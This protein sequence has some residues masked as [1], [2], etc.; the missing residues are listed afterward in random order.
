MKRFFIMIFCCAGLLNL[1]G[2]RVPYQTFELNAGKDGKPQIWGRGNTACHVSGNV[3]IVREKDGTPY[4]QFSK[5]GDFFRFPAKENIR[6][7]QGTVAFFVKECDTGREQRVWNPYFQWT[8]K[9]EVF[10]VLRLWQ[11]FEVGGGL[12][13]K[14]SRLVWCSAGTPEKGIWRHIAFSWQKQ[15][16]RLYVDGR[17]Q[18]TLLP[19]NFIFRNPGEFFTVGRPSEA[20]SAEDDFHTGRHIIYD[21]PQQAEKMKIGKEPYGAFGIRDFRIF[22]RALTPSEAAALAQERKMPPKTEDQLAL[23]FEESVSTQSLRIVLSSLLAEPG[24]KAEIRLHDSAGK[25]IAQTAAVA[26][27]GG[28]EPLTLKYGAIPAGDYQLEAT[29]AKT[30][31]KVSAVYKKLPDFPWVGNTLG[32]ADVVLPGFEPLNTGSNYASMWG[33]TYR[34]G[35]SLMLQQIVNQGR[36]ILAEPVRWRVCAGGK[37]QALAFHSTRRVSATPT[38]AVWQGEGRLGTLKVTGKVTVEYDGFMDCSLTFIPPSQGAEVESLAMEIPFRPEEAS[39]L[40]HEARRSATWENGWRSPVTP[41]GSKGVITIGS[42]DRCLQWMIESDQFYYPED[43]PGA[44]QCS[45]KDGKRIF[46]IEVIG[47]KKKI[48]RP[49]TLSWMLQAGPVKARPAHWRGWTRAGRRYIDP[50]LHNRVNYNYDWWARSPGE[51]IPAEGFPEKADRSVLKD[52][53]PCV[54]M[55]FGGYRETREKKDLNKRTPEWRRYEKEWQRLPQRLVTDPGWNEQTIDT[56]AFSWG[57]WHVWTVDRL[58][59]TT[60]VRGLYYDDWLPGASS[61][62]LAGSGYIGEGGVRRATRDIRNQR[63]IHRRVYALVKRYRPKDGVIYIH[64]SGCPILPILSFS[65]ITY[66]GEVMVWSDRIPPEG[67][68]FDTY[69]MDIF[70]MLFSCRQ[71]GTVPGFHDVTTKTLDHGGSGKILLANNQRQLWALLLLHDIHLQSAFTSGLEELRMMWLDKFGIA[72][73]DVRF[74][75]YWDPDNGAKL[76]QFGFMP[77]PTDIDRASKGYL[78]SYLRPGKALLIVVRDAPNNYAGEAQ[79]TIQLDRKKLGFSPT[80]KLAAYDME[81]MARNRIGQIDG[82]ILKVNVDCDNFTAVLIQEEK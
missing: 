49:F 24:D 40:F 45:E 47:A 1:H 64:V 65:D 36:E 62:E 10:A 71:F 31:R 17:E 15:M 29:L 58:F 6:T 68:Y 55:H 82:D 34:F 66:D 61:N 27:K 3:K 37:E 35:S 79:A 75:G 63:E 26:G 8:G 23:T 16:V 38:R 5:K 59:R 57:E 50:R 67:R 4:F 53:I 14:R 28:F 60:G 69:R 2:A 22:N 13:N 42:P 30:G 48:N 39:L 74:H 18:Q 43:N 81:S 21:A 51:A 76:L 44:L 80:A 56:K 52:K 54:S 9:D 12:W 70:R 77:D 73:D 33:R 25:V 72:E 32:S 46:T 20:H 11:P 19:V 41:L 7:E 78:A